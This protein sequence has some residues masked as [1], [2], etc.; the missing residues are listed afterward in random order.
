MQD[1]RNLK[2][3]QRSHQL[4]LEVY[5]LTSTFP[6]DERFGL[7]S[8]VRRCAASIP[9]NIAE[10]SARGSDREI[11]RFMYIAMGSAAE[12]D[13]RLLL[14]HELNYMSPSSFQA[15]AT[16]RTEKRRMLSSFTQTLKANRLTVIVRT[17]YAD[18]FQNP[19][20]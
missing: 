3:W 18:K 10:G 12:L 16:E 1:Y 7:T 17:N 4:V 13:Y 20:L 19:P 2:V 5:R 8:Q 15:L 6:A 9:S 14:A 11:A